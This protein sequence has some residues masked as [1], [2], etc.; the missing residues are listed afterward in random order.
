MYEKTY[1]NAEHQNM[2]ES[3][4]ITGE[5]FRD[6]AKDVVEH[7]NFIYPLQDDRNMTT[8]LK[9]IRDLPPDAK[10]IIPSENRKD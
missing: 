2:W 7:F 10:E 8:Y 1:S 5:L 4:F 6:L 3:I 9:Q